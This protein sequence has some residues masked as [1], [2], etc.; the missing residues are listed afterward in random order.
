MTDATID[1]AD[2]RWAE[3]ACHVESLT[4]DGRPVRFASLQASLLVMVVFMTALSI[5]VMPGERTSEIVPQVV[6][7]GLG[8]VLGVAGYVRARR[9]GR[10][11]SYSVASTGPAIEMLTQ[12]DR[13]ALNRQW[14]RSAAMDERSAPLIRALV[15]F[16]QTNNRSLLLSMTAAGCGL[17][18]AAFSLS[19]ESAAVIGVSILAVTSLFLWD[20]RRLRRLV[21]DASSVRVSA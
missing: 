3:A 10:L 7:L 21:R 4:R 1:G 14:R 16:Q 11:L 18:G 13:R 5:V 9:H 12:E 8:L 20:A 6:L 2:Q 17:L 19:T 15:A